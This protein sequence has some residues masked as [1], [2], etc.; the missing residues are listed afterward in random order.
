MSRIQ[1]GSLW[2][3][4]GERAAYLTDLRH[5]VIAAEYRAR[6]RELGMRYDDWLPPRQ[7]RQFDR[8]MVLKYGERFPLPPHA[9]WLLMAYD[10]QD[11]QEDVAER[12]RRQAAAQPAMVAVYVDEDLF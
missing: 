3:Q 4:P 6:L 7:R 8:E 10:I 1:G 5:P 9:T 2:K 12:Q 11:E